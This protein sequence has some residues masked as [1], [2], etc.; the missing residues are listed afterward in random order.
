[1]DVKMMR[2]RSSSSSS[3]SVSAADDQ[4]KRTGIQEAERLE[5]V[6]MSGLALNSLP[7]PSLDMGTICKLDLS[8]NNLQAMTQKLGKHALY[9][10]YKPALSQL[11]KT[12]LWSLYPMYKVV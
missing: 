7:I 1:M 11:G 3:A 9:P 4:R 8:S 12:Y 10:N 2:R 6:D 5:I